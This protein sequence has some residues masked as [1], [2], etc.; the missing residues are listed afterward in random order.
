MELDPAIQRKWSELQARGY[1]MTPQRQLIWQAFTAAPGHTSAEDIY[2]RLHPDFPSVNISTVYRT[3]ELFESL[4]LI[5]HVH[6]GHSMA[7]YEL[8]TDDQHQH[9]S[10]EQCGSV[11]ELDGAVVTELG[12]LLRERYG[13]E[14][15]LL[16]FAI[17]GVCRQCAA[18]RAEARAKGEPLVARGPHVRPPR[19]PH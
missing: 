9:L 5:R 6:L 3:L 17:L 10:C 11:Q 2:N 16:H 1:R 15:D 18:A 12:Q 8:A 14:A 4:G 13:F 7:Q 19:A